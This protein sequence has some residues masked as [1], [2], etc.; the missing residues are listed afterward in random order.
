LQH[1]ERGEAG[2]SQRSDRESFHAFLQGEIPF[3]R[4][5]ILR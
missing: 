4:P 2:A 3:S 5:T 1:Y